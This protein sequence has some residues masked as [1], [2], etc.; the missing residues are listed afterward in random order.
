MCNVTRGAFA[1]TLV[2]WISN[3]ALCVCVSVCFELHV[4]VNYMTIL[5]VAQQCVYGRI[6]FTGNY[7]TYASLR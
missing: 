7:I 1:K 3:N 2:L 5:S 4:T 6:F